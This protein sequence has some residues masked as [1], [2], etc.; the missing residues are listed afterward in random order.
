MEGLRVLRFQVHDPFYNM[1]L[2]E[3]IA[4]CVGEGRSPPTLR[5]YGWSPRAVSLG[6]FQEV[7]EEVD[8]DFCKKNG[9]EIVRRIT[10]GGAVLHTEGELTYSF[11]VVDD[12]SYVPAYIEESYKKICS[13]I[14]NTI[15]RLGADG[16][17]RPINDIEVGG[18]K[19]S[20]NAQTR[21]YGAVLQHGT[22]LLSVDYSLLSALRPRV[23]KLREKG[24][25][26]VSGRV[27]TLEE[28]LG[29]KISR[30]EVAEIMAEEFSKFFGIG[31]YEGEV[32]DRESELSLDLISKYRSKEWTFRR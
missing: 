9:I 30:E 8:V 31:V 25:S 29:T 18:K 24:I 19:V 27:T 1:A 13:P 20:G 2:D 16:V 17:F 28:V 21:R 15:R 22:L 12:G 14:V 10:G 5:L 7:S 4:R 3:C 26:K 6:Y 11:I 23:E 32:T